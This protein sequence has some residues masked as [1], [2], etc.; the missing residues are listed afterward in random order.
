MTTCYLVPRPAA[1]GAA[2]IDISA[3]IDLAAA[4]A[5]LFTFP[6]FIPDLRCY[7]IILVSLSGGKDSQTALRKVIR[8]CRE[9]GIPLDRVVCVYADLGDE[10]TWPGSEDMARY[11]AACYGLRFITVPKMTSDHFNPHVSTGVASREYLDKML[12]EPFAPFTFSPV[13]AAVYQLGAF[14]TAAKKLKEWDLKQ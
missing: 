14:G 4:Q 5:S 3:A 11:H 1:A 8:V 9:Q 10:V 7:D 2:D 6:E 12:A 13:G